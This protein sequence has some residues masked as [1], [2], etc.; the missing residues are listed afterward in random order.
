M[1]EVNRHVVLGKWRCK[2]FGQLG[3]VSRVNHAF[4]T[5]VDESSS[6]LVFI[7]VYNAEERFNLNG[8]KA[9]L[10]DQIKHSC[11]GGYN[12]FPLIISDTC[13]SKT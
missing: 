1:L 5:V 3:N 13:H 8:F 4:Y 12:A 9:K 10:E 2:F 7:L 6:F 11:L